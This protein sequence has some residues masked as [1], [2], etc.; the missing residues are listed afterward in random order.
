MALYRLPSIKISPG[1]VS[2]PVEL[3]NLDVKEHDL[4]VRLGARDSQRGFGCR[5]GSNSIAWVVATLRGGPL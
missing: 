5:E 4:G 3:R 1:Y 2:F